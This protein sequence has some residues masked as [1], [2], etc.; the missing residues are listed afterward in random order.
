M[1]VSQTIV[2]PSPY[3][4]R[5]RLR[6]HISEEVRTFLIR[7]G[8]DESRFQWECCWIVNSDVPN[9]TR[10]IHYKISKEKIY[11]IPHLDTLPSKQLL[12]R[13]QHDS[14]SMA[15]WKLWVK[16]LAS[17]QC[18]LRTLPHTGSNPSKTTGISD[19]TSNLVCADWSRS[20]KFFRDSQ[21]NGSKVL[22]SD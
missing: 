2:Q 18:V 17:Q 6:L 10:T 4:R 9:T 5:F 15:L 22:N 13:R 16:H 12:T 7:P 19:I 1:P 14:S 20:S 8:Q 21:Q 3:G 11:Q